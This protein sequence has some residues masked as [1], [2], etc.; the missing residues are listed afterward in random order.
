MSYREVEVDVIINDKLEPYTF[1]V[2]NINYYRTFTDNSGILK[3]MVYL[4]GS[5]KGIIL[6]IGYNV[7]KNKLHRSAEVYE[8][9]SSLEDIDYKEVENKLKDC[10]SDKKVFHS[11]L[12]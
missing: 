7:L 12:E 8:L 9:L 2:D 10:L 5:V 11:T 3:T 1:N 6:N 4:R